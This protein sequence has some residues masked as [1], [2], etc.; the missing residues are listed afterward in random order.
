MKTLG[1]VLN[2]YREKK[3]LPIS[4]LAKKT[5]IPEDSIESLEQDK[6]AKLPAPSLVRGYVLLIAS[7][8]G[9]SEETALALY[10]RD[11]EPANALSQSSPTRLKKTWSLKQN[12]LTPRFLSLAVLGMC[13]VIGLTYASW[14]W[15]SLSQPPQLSVSKPISQTVLVSP[16]IVTGQTAPDNTVTINTE[17]V[18]VDIT[19]KFHYELPLP[20]GERAIVVT[21]ED[22][23]GRKAESI[24]FITIEEKE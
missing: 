9:L 19:G 13:I 8:V 16:V 24:V 12:F 21:A 5:A 1:Q 4:V 15:F 6:Y 23:R 11:V 7:E 3:R 10:R 2:S 17:V 18:A 14:Q 20:P 22:S